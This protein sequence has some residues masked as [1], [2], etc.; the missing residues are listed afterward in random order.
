MA[1]SA[2]GTIGFLSSLGWFY[3]LSIGKRVCR[4]LYIECML[5]Y[6]FSTTNKQNHLFLVNKVIYI[7]FHQEAM[8]KS[9]SYISTLRHCHKARER[10][11]T[12]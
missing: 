4:K 12:H 3:V 2:K 10:E 9:P 7:K 5:L 1:W 8:L 11:R 6:V